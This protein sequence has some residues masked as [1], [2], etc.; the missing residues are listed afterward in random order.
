VDHWVLVDAGVPNTLLFGAHGSS[1][2]RAV[3]AKLRPT[4]RGE[5]PAQLDLII[6]KQWLCRAGA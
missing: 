5:A 4:K 6:G 2:S 1:L 3:Q